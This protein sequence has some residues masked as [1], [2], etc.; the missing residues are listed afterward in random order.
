MIDLF[1]QKTPK[2]GTNIY[3]TK[4]ILPVHE[5]FCMYVCRYA[6]VC[7]YAHMH[8]PNFCFRKKNG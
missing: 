6:Y 7:I 4:P 1:N 8:T 2:K 5:M 3:F